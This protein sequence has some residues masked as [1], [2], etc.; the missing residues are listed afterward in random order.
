MLDESGIDV[1]EEMKFSLEKT[2]KQSFSSLYSVGFPITTDTSFIDAGVIGTNEGPAQ[3][4]HGSVQLSG[5]I[6]TLWIESQITILLEV[7][8][9]SIISTR[10]FG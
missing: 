9:V 7:S 10:Y 5:T 1:N 6:Q 4:S 2:L 8:L 3:Y